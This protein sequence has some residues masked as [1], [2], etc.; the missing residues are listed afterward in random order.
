MRKLFLAIAVIAIIAVSAS[1]IFYACQKE[2]V[3]NNELKAV[4]PATE[5]E[6]IDRLSSE[7][8]QF[9]DYVIRKFI[10]EMYKPDDVFNEGYYLQLCDFLKYCIDEYSFS[11][12]E[13][14]ELK[15][16]SFTYDEIQNMI[17]TSKNDFDF[18]MFTCEGSDQ[19][20]DIIQLKC[21]RIDSIFPILLEISNTFEMFEVNYASFVNEEL[22][23]IDKIANYAPI[24]FF[25][26]MYIGSF[27]TWNESLYTDSH[28]RQKSWW[29]D[30]KATASAVWSEIKPI[31]AADAGG[32]L[33]G[34]MIGACYGA[35]G[36]VVG[37]VPGAAS[38]AAIGAVTTSAGAC[39]I[40]LISR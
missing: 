19:D 32:A 10:A 22:A 38:G 26:D 3:N 36:A 28:K 37:A 40:E 16:T 11:I 18:S 15:N 6:N 25:A 39:I 23:S 8:V 1:I 7:I 13:R 35:P 27:K 29:T 5:K 34:A 9:H 31:V 24:R 21:Q 17:T 30:V 4:L 2:K 12:M 33:T 20:F 14:E